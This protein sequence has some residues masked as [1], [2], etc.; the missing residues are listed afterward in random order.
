MTPEELKPYQ[1][2]VSYSEINQ[3][4]S[5]EKSVQGLLYTAV[6]TRPDIAF[7][8]SRLSRFLTNLSPQRHAAADRVS[9]Y[10]KRYRTTTWKS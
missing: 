10:S 6:T 7:I 8:A 5:N 9:S 1:G 2:R 3:L 4:G